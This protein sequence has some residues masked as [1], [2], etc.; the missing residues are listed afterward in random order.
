[1]NTFLLHKEYEASIPPNQMKESLLTNNLPI[2]SIT[3]LRDKNLKEGELI[4]NC[5]RGKGVS[6]SLT[7]DTRD[8]LQDNASIIP[9]KITIARHKL[10]M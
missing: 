10:P 9:Q 7:N 2:R 1:M 5:S 6:D 8:C 3:D 4:K